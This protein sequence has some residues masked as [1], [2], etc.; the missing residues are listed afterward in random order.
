MQQFFRFIDI[1]LDKIKHKFWQLINRKLPVQISLFNLNPFIS[2]NPTSNIKI[3]LENHLH[4]SSYPKSFSLPTAGLQP[5]PNHD[6]IPKKAKTQNYGHEKKLQE[7]FDL[8]RGILLKSINQKNLM[9][10]YF[11]QK[12]PQR[13]DQAVPIL[14][15][16]SKFPPKLIPTINTYSHFMLPQKRRPNWNLIFIKGNQ[17]FRWDW[18]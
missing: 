9:W 7:L 5:P 12:V 16:V 3:Y 10:P 13:M 18:S 6:P 1:T 4:A 2:L 14:P 17:F 11:P 8:S 15:Y